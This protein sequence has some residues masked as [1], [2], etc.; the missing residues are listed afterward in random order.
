MAN[1]LYGIRFNDGDVAYALSKNNVILYNVVVKI[2]SDLPAEVKDYLSK[3]GK[4]EDIKIKFTLLSSR[5]AREL[6]EN[7]AVSYELS[8]S[9]LAVSFKP[10][11]RVQSLPFYDDK[12]MNVTIP[13]IQ[14]GFGVMVCSIFDKSGRHLGQSN[15]IRPED[16]ADS[17]GNLKPRSEPYIVSDG[18]GGISSYIANQIKVGWG[19]FANG[20]AVG[21]EFRFPIKADFYV[22]AEN[23][24]DFYPT[25]DKTVYTGQPG[26]K[27]QVKVTLWNQGEYGITD[28]A[29][30]EYGT[31]WADATWLDKEAKLGKWG[32]K[33][34]TVEF[35]VG[36]T[37][38]KYVFRANVDGKTPETEI[39]QENNA[40]T[41]TV[42]PEDTCTDV[43][44]A[45]LTAPAVIRGGQPATVKAVIARKNDSPAR[46]VTVQVTNTGILSQNSPKT[47]TIT[48]DRGQSKTITWQTGAVWKDTVKYTVKAEVTD[49][50]DCIPG[51]NSK[52]VQIKFVPD[53]SAAPVDNDTWTS[54]IDR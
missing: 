13:Q 8:S 36:Q 44:I 6:F 49:A 16:I 41:I 53:L 12:Y 40:I 3:G 7:G 47:Q 48:L 39:N 20:G 24:P 25:S 37:E 14:N 51:N 43:Y 45:S 35:T 31:G 29:W 23:V 9:Q 22:P 38:K 28:F 26:Q 50:K 34:Y 10:I 46:A 19:T 2:P 30:T 5:A 21:L 1:S 11:F 54:I 18:K 27:V 4:L 17:D 52:Q 33:D 42:K 15:N 32:K